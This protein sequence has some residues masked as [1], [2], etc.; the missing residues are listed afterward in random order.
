[1]LCQNQIDFLKQLIDQFSL[2]HFADNLPFPKDYALTVSSGNA[3][4]CLTRLA[5]AIHHAAHYCNRYVLLHVG[6]FSFYF[7]RNRR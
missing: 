3:H 5:W 6:K 1:M 4:V 2:R 7:S